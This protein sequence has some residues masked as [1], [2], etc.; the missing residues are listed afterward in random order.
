M[1]GGQ[2]FLPTRISDKRWAEKRR[3]KCLLLVPALHGYDFDILFRCA[4]YGKYNPLYEL[5]VIAS[6]NVALISD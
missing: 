6:L 1:Q 5:R 3:I 2:A 4:V